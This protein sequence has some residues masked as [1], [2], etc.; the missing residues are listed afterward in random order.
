[1]QMLSRNMQYI[2]DKRYCLINN[3]FC[4][5]LPRYFLHWF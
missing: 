5:C 4:S 2:L 1:L 3:L